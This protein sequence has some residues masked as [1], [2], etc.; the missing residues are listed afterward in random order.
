MYSNVISVLVA[1]AP[2][3]PFHLVEIKFRKSYCTCV[4]FD[5]GD[6]IIVS[7]ILKILRLSF[8]CDGQGADR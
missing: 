8:S 6:G 5:I 4:C 2:C 7:K 3:I 1:V